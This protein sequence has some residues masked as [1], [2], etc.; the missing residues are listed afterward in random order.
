ML[1]SEGGLEP[2]PRGNCTETVRGHLDRVLP[3]EPYKRVSFPQPGKV[4]HGEH[5]IRPPASAFNRLSDE[6]TGALVLD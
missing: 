3:Q 5:G 4:H 2:P 1:V 6:R